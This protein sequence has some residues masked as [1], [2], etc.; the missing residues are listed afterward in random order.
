MSSKGHLRK[1]ADQLDEWHVVRILAALSHFAIIITLI[2]FVIDLF[3]R[4]EDR[5]RFEEE[6]AEWQFGRLVSAWSLLTTKSSGNSGKITAINVL[7]A[8]GE[9]IVGLDLSCENNGGTLARTTTLY[10]RFVLACDRGV[11]LSGL[12]LQ[13]DTSLARNVFSNSNLSGVNLSK[14]R[15]EGLVI[16]DALLTGANITGAR[17][18]D[19]TLERVDFQSALGTPVDR[20]ELPVLVLLDAPEREQYITRFEDVRFR[21]ASLS[22]ARLLGASFAGSQAVGINLTGTNLRHADMTGVSFQGVDINEQTITDGLNISGA[23]LRFFCQRR[24]RDHAM[25]RAKL[26]QMW[27]WDDRPPDVDPRN[28]WQ[29]WTLCSASLRP[30]Y[31]RQRAYGRPREC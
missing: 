4:A 18:D 13:S 19:T 5:K 7:F 25:C 15:F 26:A 22:G 6:T 23:K 12:E 2:A 14:A 10:D 21:N 3:A 9:D 30:A 20:P 27:A 24:N 1:L 28:T 17:F 11:F 31:Q 29:V 8:A 16:R